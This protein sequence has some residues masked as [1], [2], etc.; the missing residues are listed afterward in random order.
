MG[1]AWAKM[2]PLQESK[3]GNLSSI[4]IGKLFING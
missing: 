3:M 1:M 4:G 2:V